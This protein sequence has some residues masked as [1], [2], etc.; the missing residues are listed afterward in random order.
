MTTT[1][2]ASSQPTPQ[3]EHQFTL[4]ASVRTAVGGVLMGLA[5]LV[6]GVSGGTMLLAAGV[7]Q[8]F[9]DAIAECVRFRF[10]PWV[11][12]TLALIILSAGLAIL[13][14][15]GPV[16]QLVIEQRWIMYAL[17][18]GLTLG[19]VPI[20]WQQA[21]PMQTQSW[22]GAAAGFLAMAALA[23]A[24]A[25]GNVAANNNDS[26]LF[27]FLAG[28]AGASAMILPGV[29]GGYLLLLLGA[30]IPM[31]AAIDRVKLGLEARDTAAVLDEWRVVI[32]LGLGVAVGIIVVSQAL[33]YL[34][35][36]HAPPTLG[37]LLGLLVGAVAGL[38]PFQRAIEP[39]PGDILKGQT[40]TEVIER[41]GQRLA[42]TNIDEIGMEDWPTGYFTPSVPQAAGALALAA[43][44]FLATAALGM[45][46]R[47]E[48]NSAKT[49]QSTTQTR[50]EA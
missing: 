46:K 31:L 29:S 11:I 12:T 4:A 35:R 32:P 30:Y 13:L 18:V 23:I 14:L 37:V 34:L 25:T 28:I 7:Y 41:E 50:T 16:K 17:F 19:G 49:T 47:R 44:G 9:I 43:A 1:S 22:I 33:R 10:K 42:I 39:Q 45:T 36:K 38:W 24:Q 26:M 2:D 21:K 40:V 3:P 8:R 6:P 27:M 48:H 15:A 20:V 5:N